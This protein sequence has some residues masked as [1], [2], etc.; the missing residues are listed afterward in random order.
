[1][2]PGSPAHRTGATL[3]LASGRLAGETVIELMRHG[4]PMTA[5]HLSLY[6]DKLERS[7]LL[8][9]LQRHQPERKQEQSGPVADPRLLA[10]ASSGLGRAGNQDGRSRQRLLLRHLAGKSP[11]RKVVDGLA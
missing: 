7:A 1:M 5:R 2:Q 8:K 10:Q 6:R 11:P 9:M 4:R 3:A